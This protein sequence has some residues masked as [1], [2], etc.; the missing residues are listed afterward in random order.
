MR[1]HRFAFREK[2]F[3]FD[4]ETLS[5]LPEY[6]KVSLPKA[7]PGPENP[8]VAL[9]AGRRVEILVNATQ[10]CNLAC[11]YCFVHRGRFS[12]DHEQPPDLTPDLAEQLIRVLPEAI[13]DAD[14]YCIHFYGGEPLMNPGAVGAAVEEAHR[15]GDPRFTFAVTTNGTIDPGVTVPLLL[16]GNFSVVVSIDG[17]EQIHDEVRRDTD[18]NPTHAKVRAFLDRITA[19]HGL[20]V[21]GSSVI[22]H[23]WPLADAEQ[24]LGSLPVTAI[25][26]QAARVPEDHPLALT[27]AE[28]DRYLQ[29]LEE[30]AGSVI[31]GLNRG[32]LPQDDRFNSRVLQLVCRARRESFCGAG[33]SIF[34]M[35]CDG[36]I[37]PCVLHAGNK[38][39][40]LGHI[41]DPEHG[42]VRKG[43]EWVDGRTRRGTCSRC[44]AAPF[45]GGGCPAMLSVCGEDEC[46]YTRKVCEM[47]IAIY[48]SVLHK[49][50]LLLLA[51]IE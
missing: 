24:Y 16:E 12:Y 38:N 3:S 22:R 37:Y 1:L 23:G 42:W 41:S 25:K 31:D 26:A 10:R 5:L 6:G 35:G 13:P 48:G 44:W 51:G 46:E 19:G 50:D 33:T 47:A 4:P 18:G 15:G 45:C 34:G 7:T 49:P 17:P 32:E 21:R 40:E 11:P 43:K 20:S 2:T 39:L 27:G 30:I 8:V 36:T 29:E 9:P 14:E 28:R